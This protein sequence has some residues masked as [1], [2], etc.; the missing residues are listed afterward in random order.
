MGGKRV[1][2]LVLVASVATVFT[3]AELDPPATAIGPVDGVA[4][5]NGDGYGDLVVGMPS[6]DYSVDVSGD[7]TVEVGELQDGGA[8]RATRS[9]AHC[10]PEP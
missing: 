6:V 5:F 7:G 4:D 2:T 8:G 1:I 9:P 10:A 3:P